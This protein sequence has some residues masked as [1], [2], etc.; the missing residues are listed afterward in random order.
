MLGRRRRR[1]Q[2]APVLGLRHFGHLLLLAM[3]LLVWAFTQQGGPR[4]LAQYRWMDV[5]GEGGGALMLALWMGYLR[6]SRPAGRVTDLLCL[7]LAAMMLGGF[8]DWLDEFWLLPKSVLWDNWMESGLTPLGM[9]LLTW[10]LHLWRG[11]QQVLNAQLRERERLFREHRQVDGLTRLG[12]AGY[13]ARQV[14]LERRLDRPAQLLMLGW[15]GFDARARA[16]G[17]AEADRL[18]QNAAQLILLHLGPG[19]LLCRYGG[20]RFVLLLPG[21]DAARAR[22]LGERLEAALALWDGGG[23]GTAGLGLALRTAWAPVAQ[24]TD[25]EALMLALLARLERS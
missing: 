24:G 18:L 3:A 19:E 17:L 13:M 5:L 6:A 22:R 12:D 25:P 7:G 16:L 11:E 21:A 20:D 10:G 14:A 1:L 9:G 15:Q 2:L 8:V 23:D 4:P